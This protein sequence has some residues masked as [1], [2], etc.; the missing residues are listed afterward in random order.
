MSDRLGRPRPPLTSQVNPGKVRVQVNV[1]Y[2]VQTLLNRGTE[3]D[4]PI[5]F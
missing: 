1:P 4:T 3:D 2:F 5:A